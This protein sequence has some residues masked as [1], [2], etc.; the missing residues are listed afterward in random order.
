MYNLTPSG[1]PLRQQRLMFTT[2][3][4]NHTKPEQAVNPFVYLV[5]FVVEILLLDCRT[6]CAYLG[7]S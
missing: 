3:N 1:F 2:K 5:C 6:S 4:T 7:C